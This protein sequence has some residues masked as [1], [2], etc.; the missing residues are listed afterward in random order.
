VVVQDYG[1][2]PAGDRISW[3]LQFLKGDWEKVR[4]YWARREMV[5]ITDSAGETFCARVVVKSYSR[6]SSFEGKAVEAN[7]EL[8]MV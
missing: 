3:T 1:Y 7:L 2:I 4:G 6:L 8:W 5:D